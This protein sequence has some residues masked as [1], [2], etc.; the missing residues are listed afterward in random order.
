M[1]GHTLSGD[2]FVPIEAFDATPALQ[3]LT[4]NEPRTGLPLK[5]AKSFEIILQ[6]VPSEGQK[7]KGTISPATF[8]F[9][10]N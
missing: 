8:N 1:V 5:G 3:K 6:F 2:M 9:T 10:V 7:V 4:T